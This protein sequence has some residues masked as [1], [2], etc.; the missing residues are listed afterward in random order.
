M[1]ERIWNEHIWGGSHKY[2]TS[3]FWF[4]VKSET[5]MQQVVTKVMHIDSSTRRYQHIII[6]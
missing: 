2:R 4:T 6:V 1:R 5:I 3:R